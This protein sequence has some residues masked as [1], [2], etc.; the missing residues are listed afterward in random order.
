MKRR[1]GLMWTALSLVTLAMAAQVTG[2]GCASDTNNGYSSS[3]PGRQTPPPGPSVYE[4]ITALELEPAQLPA[5][6]AVLED[7][8]DEREAIFT[9]SQSGMGERPDP[10]TMNAVCAEMTDL[11]ERTEKRLG[12]LLTTEQMA[13][14]REMIRKA[15]QRRDQMGSQ[16][17]GRRGGPGGGK[18]GSGGGRTGAGGW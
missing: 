2:T 7:A 5:V 18:G 12:E 17:G 16:M 9:T 8:E 3:R 13:E 15:E 11:N 6:R 14:Y 1:R 10:S 4:V